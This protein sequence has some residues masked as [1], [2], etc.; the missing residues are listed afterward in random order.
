MRFFFYGTLIDAD[1]R[2][3]V[4]GPD[5]AAWRISDGLLRH[6]RTARIAGRPYPAIVPRR[7][8]T[9]A[10]ILADGVDG[11]ALPRL[12][13]YEGAEYTMRMLEIEIA[14]EPGGEGA[15]PAVA[16][17]CTFAAS[18]ICSVT[19]AGW[20][21]DEWRRRHRKATIAALRARRPA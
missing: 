20:N 21:L 4:L 6:W 11:D 18:P 9:T 3:C 8:A 13:A 14:A 16:T 7:G 19:P 10:G 17:A 15:G 12:H 5:A 2:A 1:V